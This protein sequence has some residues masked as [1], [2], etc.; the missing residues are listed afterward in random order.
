MT[1]KLIIFDVNNAACNIIVC[2]NG[3]G[4]MVDCGSH[5]D[6]ECPIDDIK[7]IYLLSGEKLSDHSLG[8][9]ELICGPILKG[10]L[11]LSSSSLK[12]M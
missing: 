12:E 9:A 2:P 10:P 3:Y 1:M 6:K 7:N 4:L 11:Q 5:G 8:S